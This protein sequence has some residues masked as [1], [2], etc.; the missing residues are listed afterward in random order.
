MNLKTIEMPERLRKWAEQ[1]ARHIGTHIDVYYTST[2]ED[3]GMQGS[4]FRRKG[5]RGNRL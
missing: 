4:P 5:D 2:L 3:S 1:Q